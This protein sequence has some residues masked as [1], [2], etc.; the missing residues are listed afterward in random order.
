MKL[1]KM[2]DFVLEQMNEVMLD[3]TGAVCARIGNYA[4]FLN[5]P[6]ELGMFFPCDDDRLFSHKPSE[7]DHSNGVCPHESYYYEQAM[8]RVLFKHEYSLEF[9]EDM[10][11]PLR[12]LED[13]VEFDFTLTESAQRQIGLWTNS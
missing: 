3:G 13:C 8:K 4:N 5:R 6:L 2:T 11:L 12:T 7:S 9:I 1:I 10:I